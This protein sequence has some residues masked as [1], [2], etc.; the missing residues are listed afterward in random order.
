M[1]CRHP[2]MKKS[3]PNC[4]RHASILLF[5]CEECDWNEF[6]AFLQKVYCIFIFVKFTG[7]LFSSISPILRAYSILAWHTEKL[8][9]SYMPIHSN[10]SRNCVVC[11]NASNDSINTDYTNAKK[12]MILS[13]QYYELFLLHIYIEYI[14]FFS[15]LNGVVVLLVNALNRLHTANCIRT[16]LFKQFEFR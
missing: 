9:T 2:P 3:M 8:P 12:N 15:N 16:D 13:N 14:Y 10:D 11:A 4:A 1:V 5:A 7:A 6:F